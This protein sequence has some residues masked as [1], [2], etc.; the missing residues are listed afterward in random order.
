MSSLAG[1]SAAFAD[2]GVVLLKG[3]LDQAAL[4]EAQAAYDWSLAHPGPLA[5]KVTQATDALFYNDLL[6][7]ACLDAYAPMLRN[8]P[9]PTIISHI[10]GCPGVWFMYEQVF[11]K[12]GGEARRTP[13]HQDTSYLSIAGD[14]LA[15]AWIS[16]DPALAADS[17][18][19]VCGS[20]RGQLYNGSRFTLGDDTAP[21]YQ[22]D[23]MPQLPDIERTRD[24]WDIR[25]W[26]VDPG[27][28]IVFHPS[29]LHGGA[30]THA[31]SRR[32]TLTLRFF[33]NDA[34]YEARPAPAGPGGRAFH[35]RKTQGDPLHDPD[36]LQ[37][38]P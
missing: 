38:L 17:L 11:L 24:Q 31:G 2:D 1:L 29:L 3:A 25:S 6:N 20:H 27:D 35:E 33:G 22:G 16:F 10:W 7:P 28:V 26:A 32:R 34:R 18:E 30:P 15:V 12:E 14:H 37:L 21:L 5:S 4:A 23:C 36:F 9:L 8:S 13:W 19:F